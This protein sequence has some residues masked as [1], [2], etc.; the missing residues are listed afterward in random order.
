MTSKQK[1]AIKLIRNLL[2]AKRNGNVKREQTEYDKLYDFCG[3]NDFDFDNVLVGGTK[4]LKQNSIGA[5]M[6]GII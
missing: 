1:Q 4:W 5:N 2:T 3:T 6:N